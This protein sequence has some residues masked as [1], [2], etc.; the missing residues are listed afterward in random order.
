[1]FLKDWEVAQYDSGGKNHREMRVRQRGLESF[2]EGEQE[3]LITLSLYQ[4]G[5]PWKT[6]KLMKREPLFHKLYKCLGQY[7][8]IR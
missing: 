2:E 3:A 5:L 7:K 1:M 6:K 8:S 4:Q